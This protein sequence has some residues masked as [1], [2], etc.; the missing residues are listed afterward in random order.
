MARLTGAAPSHCSAV[1][2]YTK[3]WC[4]FCIAAKRLFTSLGIPFEEI[5]VDRDPELRWEVSARAGNW[6]TVPMIFVGDHF[7]G[8][9]T[10]ASALHRTGN[11]LSLCK[12]AAA[13]GPER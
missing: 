10:E 9:F 6:P 13:T 12:P 7:V 8:G 1:R 11:L 2:I 3:R 5:P 4:G